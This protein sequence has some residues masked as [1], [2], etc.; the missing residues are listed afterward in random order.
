MYYS[1][2]IKKLYYSTLANFIIVRECIRYINTAIYLQSYTDGQYYQM[3][4]NDGCKQTIIA[5]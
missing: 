2:S 5:S 1:T 4:I 3:N